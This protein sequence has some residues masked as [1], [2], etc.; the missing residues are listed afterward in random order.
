M[1]VYKIETLEQRLGET[2]WQS[3]FTMILLSLFAG[4]A[5]LL[6]AAGIYAVI[7]YLAAQRTREIGIRMALGARPRDVLWMVT[8]EGVGVACAG[9]LLGALGAA[10]LM[11]MLTT[12]LYGVT[13]ADPLTFALVAV[14]LLAVTAAACFIPAR[15]AA[16][17]DPVKALGLD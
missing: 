11:R 2:F 7:S 13:A 10:A 12:R 3:R 5:L 9:V 17:I 4:L 1:N 8:A 15:R 6:A 14:L 16:R